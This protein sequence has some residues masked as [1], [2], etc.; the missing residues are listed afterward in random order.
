MLKKLTCP[1]RAL[2][3]ILCGLVL[4]VA[5][6]YIA[7]RVSVPL[8]IPTAYFESNNVRPETVRVEDP[9]LLACSFDGDAIV[10]R[11]LA[12]GRTGI[13][14]GDDLIAVADCYP[15]G[16]VYD[17]VTGCYSGDSGVEHVLGAFL[18]FASCVMYIEMR[19]QLRKQF[20]HYSS[21]LMIALCLLTCVATVLSIWSAVLPEGQPIVLTLATLCE[22]IAFLSLPL[23]A[24]FTAAMLVSNTCLIR[25]EGARIRNALG[26]LIGAALLAAVYILL[27]GGDFS[28]SADELRVSNALRNFVAGAIVF[29][30]CKLA[31]VIICGVRAAGMKPHGD[32]D[33]VLILGCRLNCEG[34]LTP[35]LRGRVD[36]ALEFARS[37]DHMPVFIPCGGKGADEA[38][39]EAAAMREYL[40]DQ[41]IPEE[42]I[43]PEDQS[44][45]T[46][47]N[48]RN[49]KSVMREGG[50]TAF[51]TT[52]YHVFRSG[53]WA[54][55]NGIRAEGMG[56]KTRWYY[57][58][59]AFMREYLA[60]IAANLGH[61]IAVLAALGAQSA[62]LAF[63]FSV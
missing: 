5:A 37:R 61:E 41:G 42:K 31:A 25:R 3:L 11:G 46:W 49:A 18:L 9:S 55:R 47:E 62:L 28:G 54:W 6:G 12:R 40:M 22:T 38:R 13:L 35:L 4:S 16:V 7:M 2:V 27:R 30:E 51:A 29:T 10:L 24:A 44:A 63:L 17:Y 15:D 59:N 43:I 21:P 19:R 58:P 45:N 32:K 26:T 23:L 14:A 60:L 50:R 33:Y 57:W 36:C 53:V 52:N 20:F 48:M 39:S 34:G 8:R 56:S 1:R